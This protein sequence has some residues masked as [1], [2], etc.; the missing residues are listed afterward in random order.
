M[1]QTARDSGVTTVQVGERDLTLRAVHAAHGPDILA[2]HR[3]VF[4]SNVDEN[5]L[6]WKYGRPGQGGRCPGVGVWDGAELVAYCGG[7]PRRLWMHGLPLD[8]LQI[9]DVMV[10]PEWR[11]IL[12]RRGPF[13][14]ACRHFYDSYIGEKKEFQLGFGFPNFRAMRLPVKLGLAWDG[15]AI[16]SLI[17]N[18]TTALRGRSPVSLHWI[19]KEI[20]P[21]AS[22]FE[23][24]VDAAWARMRSGS[25]GMTLGQRDASYLRW[26]YV[27][28]PVEPE[29][30]RQYRFFLLHHRWSR[31]IGGV[32]VLDFGGHR[33]QWLDWVGEPMLMPVAAQACKWEVMQLGILEMSAWASTLVL[34]TLQE[35]GITARTIAARLG[36]PCNSMVEEHDLVN[37]RWWLMGGDTDFL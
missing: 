22:E 14:Y 19:W 4:G 10:A 9:G 2:L 13:F 5:W 30:N 20:H 34:E 37:M 12:T 31:R 35:S 24:A 29:V 21:G 8:G 27:D 3:R 7:V 26:R 33:A 11:G 32:A 16:H 36:V 17:W 28:R 23:T 6:E 15:G 1:T 18:L 25:N